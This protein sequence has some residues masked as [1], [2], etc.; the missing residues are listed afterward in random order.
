MKTETKNQIEKNIEEIRK[1]IEL[2]NISYEEIVYLQN[3]VECI[4]KS[5]ITL[6]QW[7][8]VEDDI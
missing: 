2:E 4:D 7:A 5:D 3:H 1:S 8:G 6:L